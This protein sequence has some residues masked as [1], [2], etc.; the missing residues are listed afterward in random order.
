MVFVSV[1]A[2]RQSRRREGLEPAS[3]LPPPPRERLP[4]VLLLKKPYFEQLFGLMQ[5]LGSFKAISD[6]GV[7]I[8]FEIVVD[9]IYY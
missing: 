7:S 9:F 8:S 4:V 2:P 3:T 6:T 1:G 5:H